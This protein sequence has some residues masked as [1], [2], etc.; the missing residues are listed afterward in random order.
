MLDIL[1]RNK[2]D[3]E[4][5]FYAYLKKGKEQGQLAAIQDLRS[6]ATLLFTLYNGIRVVSKVRP[7]RK[8]LSEAIEVAMSLLR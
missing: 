6:V 1:E 8:Q 5:L 3:V 4:A 7:Q 2:E